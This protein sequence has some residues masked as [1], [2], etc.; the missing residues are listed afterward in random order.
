MKAIA[1]RSLM[2]GHAAIT[3]MELQIITSKVFRLFPA[4][5]WTLR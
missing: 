2:R 1:A 5:L 4:V 3:A